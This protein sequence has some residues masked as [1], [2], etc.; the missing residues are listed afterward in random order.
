M[1]DV[2]CS[3]YAEV[4]RR[5][6][7]F[8]YQ[9]CLCLLKE[10]AYLAQCLK[11]LTIIIGKEI[12]AEFNISPQVLFDD[13]LLCWNCISCFKIVIKGMASWVLNDKYPFVLSACLLLAFWLCVF[14]LIAIICF[15]FFLLLMNSQLFCKPEY[16]NVLFL[17]KC[18]YLWCFKI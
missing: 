18:K 5:R 16:H 10:L 17:S 12:G 7:V 4:F 9:R 8:I 13:I 1:W 15:Q 2:Y 14:V 3:V 11:V 6:K